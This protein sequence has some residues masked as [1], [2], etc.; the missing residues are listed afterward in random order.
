MENF[1]GN[2]GL[3]WTIVIAVLILLAITAILTFTARWLFDLGPWMT[4]LLAIVILGAI[5][6][7]IAWALAGEMDI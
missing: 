5:C 3:D 2:L 1:L 4:L 6:G 7:L